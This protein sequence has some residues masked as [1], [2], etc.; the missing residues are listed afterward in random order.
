MKKRIKVLLLMSGLL[1]LAGWGCTLI[2]LGIGAASDA[3]KTRQVSGWKIEEIPIGSTVEIFCKDE[4]RVRGKFISSVALFAGTDSSSTAIQVKQGSGRIISVASDNVDR[5]AIKTGK[6]K[7]TGM[8]VGLAADIITGVLVVAAINSMEFDLYD[9]AK[10]S[11]SSSC[12]IIYSYDGLDSRPDAEVFAGAIFQ[13]AERPDWD[14][15]DFLREDEQGVC[16]LKMANEFDETQQVDFVKLL[17][18]DHP[19][20]SRVLPSFSGK[21]FTVNDL[22]NARVARDYAGADV[23]SR[24]RKTDGTFWLSN[25]F[26]RDLQNADDLRDG[27]LLE[28]DRSVGTSAAALVLNVQNTPWASE[29][30]R[31]LL[32][33]PGRELPQ[34]YDMLNNSPAAREELVD[35][36]IRE[37]MIK[38]YVWNE[39][40]MTWRYMG[41]VW[42]VGSALPKDIVVELDLLGTHSNTLKVKLECPPGIWMLN[43]VQIDYSFYNLP[44][45]MEEIAARSA[46]DQNRHDVLPELSRAD[47]QYHVMPTTRDVVDLEFVVP[48]RKPGMERTY[49]FHSGGYY[50][51]HTPAEGVPQPERMQRML[52]ESGA[53]TRFALESLYWETGRALEGR[54]AMQE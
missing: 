24:I 42:E 8:M 12:P 4:R 14:N 19:A 29:V 33:L 27:L 43:S 1:L 54:Q 44:N 22:Q 17:S 13:A 47:N 38:V 39:Q 31:K 15:L 46:V 25:P 41:H 5:V 51:V 48:A 28:F 50:T 32:E 30:Q 52:R 45:R 2:G 37:G 6:G 11:G 40:E 26:N 20:G 53:F 35:A 18:I 21:L 3:G 16:R 49:I 34:W 7:T 36:M 23:R 10:T 9:A